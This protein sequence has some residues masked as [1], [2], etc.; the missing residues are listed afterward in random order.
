MS[1]KAIPRANDEAATA[2]KSRP[3][4]RT[5]R[6]SSSSM[7]PLSVVPNYNSVSEYAELCSA[8]KAAYAAAIT[9]QHV[10]APRVPPWF[11]RSLADLNR[12]TGLPCSATPRRG[13]RSAYSGRA[14]GHQPADALEGLQCGPNL[15]A[16]R[17]VA[18]S[19]GR[20][21]RTTSSSHG[22][23]ISRTHGRGTRAR[24]RPGSEWRPPPSCRP[25]ASS[26]TV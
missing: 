18:Q 25:P 7:K 17:T 20:F 26:G 6:G 19:C 16:G 5:P 8:A 21:V 12:V 13:V 4:A 15:L 9:D 23:S 11:F 3:R 2:K 24:L 10:S 22:R 1:Y 14:G